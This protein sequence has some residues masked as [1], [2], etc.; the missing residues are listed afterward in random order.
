MIR[1]VW[2]TGGDA[3][4]TTLIRRCRPADEPARRRWALQQRDRFAPP[5]YGACVLPAGTSGFTADDWTRVVNEVLGEAYAAGQVIGHFGD[6][7]TMRQGLFESESGA[8]PAMR[9]TCSSTGAAGN[10][11][12]F[13]LQSMFAGATGIAA[14]VA[15][16]RPGWGRR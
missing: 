13:N 3:N 7:E 12:T 11:A 1:D 6:V 16:W 2:T 9:P 8:L 5:T 4:P 14:S 10:T 15:G